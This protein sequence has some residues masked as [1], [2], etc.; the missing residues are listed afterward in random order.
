M[1]PCSFPRF[2]FLGKIL[3]SSPPIPPDTP[4]HPPLT[5]TARSPRLPHPT[6]TLLSL[7]VYRNGC[8]FS[9]SYPAYSSNSSC[10]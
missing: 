5:Y 6:P 4:T 2:L 9:P 7:L 8:V 1:N 10:K 3:R